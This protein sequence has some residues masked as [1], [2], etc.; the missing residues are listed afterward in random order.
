MDSILNSIKKLLGIREDYEQF[1]VDVKIH[2]NSVLAALQQM[3]IGK[4]GF[5][6]SDSSSTWDEFLGDNAENFPNLEMV[7]S[8]VFMRVRLIFDPPTSG[9]AVEAYN[10]AIEEFEWRAHVAIETPYF[11]GE[12]PTL[13]EDVHS[14]PDYKTYRNT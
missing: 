10:K 7:K 14:V 4:A 1:D 12:A 6:I 13:A 9:T 2:I 8:Y 11:G 3:G 5:A